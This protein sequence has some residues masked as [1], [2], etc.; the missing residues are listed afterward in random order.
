MVLFIVPVLPGLNLC[1]LT[2]SSS[3]ICHAGYKVSQSHAAPQAIKTDAPAEIVWRLIQA[4]CIQM[5]PGKLESASASSPAHQILCKLPA[6]DANFELHPGSNPDSIKFKL[7][8]FQTNPMPNWGPMSRP[9][10][11]NNKATL[12]SERPKKKIKN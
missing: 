7:I 9:G 11:K 5:D 4:W 12:E 1:N 2:L 6:M 3:A 8:R 10:A